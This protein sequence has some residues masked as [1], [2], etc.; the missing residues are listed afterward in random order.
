MSALHIHLDA[1]GG[2]AGDMLVAA[3]TDAMP[4]LRERVLA[5][6]A[7]VLPEG[8]GSARFEEGVSGGLR[9]SRLHL[10]PATTPPDSTHGCEHVH[11]HE[12]SDA[13]G[14]FTDMVARIRSCPLTAGTAEQAVAILTHIAEAEAQIH[15]VSVVDVHFHEIADW[16][17]LMDVVAAGSIAAAIDASW[18]VSD[19]PAGHGF[20]RTRHGMLPVPAPATA[21]MLTG[22]DWRDDGVGGERVTPTGAAILKHLIRNPGAQPRPG[23]RLAGVGVGAGTRELP[24]MP[25]VLR[26]LVFDRRSASS[27]RES[28]FDFDSDRVA[29]VAFD[30]DDMTG[31]EVGVAAE[32]L[33]ALDG[34]LDVAIASLLGKKHRPLCGFRLLVEPG[35]LEAVKRT[36]FDE[37]ATLGLR[38]HFE[39]RAMLRRT[40]DSALAEPA[41]VRIKRTL[42]P[43]GTRTS[44]IESDDLVDTAGLANRRALKM[45]NEKET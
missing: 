28:G 7:A 26:A 18:S 5:D 34:V 23:G 25:N 3:L 40:F 17:S 35:N 8:A 42:R 39:E 11:Q 2:I 36:C 6:V 10:S 15:A 33:R 27:D 9:A 37:T 38:W 44:K 4:R 13:A 30:I 22:F 43:D 12:R 41:A 24:G 16:D 20:I 19:L 32:R 45:K 21:A 29:V 1:V 31:E 14:D